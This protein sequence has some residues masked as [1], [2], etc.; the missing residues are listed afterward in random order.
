MR[1]H[2][3]SALALLGAVA[4]GTTGGGS[5]DA[6]PAPSRPDETT[7]T[8]AAATPL[9]PGATVPPGG[10][11]GSANVK[12]YFTRGESLEAV[13]R[14]VP[15]VARV[16]AE[17]VKALLAGP[18]AEETRS[19]L[20]TS[21]PRDT[22]FLNLVIDDGVAEVDLSKA[23]ES[24]GGTLS[25]TM[26]L[27]Q[28]TCTLD[29]FDSVRGVRFSLDGKLV[30]V[31]SGDGIV[32]DQPVTC[33]GYGDLLKPSSVPP[34]ATTFAGIWPFASQSEAD[35]YADGDDTLFR[36]AVDTAREFARRYVGMREPVTFGGATP[37]GR[38]VEVRVGFGTGEGGQRIPDPRPTMT[39]QLQNVG[40]RDGDRNPWT[41]VA[42]TSE[43]I[44][45]DTP[46]ALAPVSSPLSVSGG[47]HVYE[48]N[49]AME[50]RED[51][52]V[53]GQSLGQGF[54][55]GGGDALGPFS[56][57]VSFRTP[58]KPAGA[59]VFYEPSAADGQNVLRA[60]V[61]RVQFT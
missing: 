18:T 19:G 29:Q 28:V 53:A 25:L 24:G 1:R 10:G 33:A 4:C 23:F 36:N 42:A 26:R 44:V 15:R 55:T 46:E 52:M 51:G 40:D 8:T 32:V 20:G 45:V 43:Q 9:Q 31:F 38:L 30:N 50:V 14:A 57:Q 5:I 22:R 61:V 47:A 17:T 21:I 37:A 58:S 35:A 39:V 27:A 12:V 34:T 49:V 41:V 56:G 2:L 60:T 16:G 7:T 11:G 54:L 48:G 3:L 59:V 6:G 13:N